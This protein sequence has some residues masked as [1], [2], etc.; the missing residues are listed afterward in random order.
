MPKK[1]DAEDESL[2]EGWPAVMR[3]GTVARYLERV[4]NFDGRGYVDKI[5]V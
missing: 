1:P 2:E 4:M 5:G 3:I